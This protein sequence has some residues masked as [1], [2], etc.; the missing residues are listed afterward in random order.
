VKIVVGRWGLKGDIEPN[1]E[2]LHEAGADLMATTLA[3][4]RD[5]LNTWL[6]I[7]GG[8]QS[9]ASELGDARREAV[10]V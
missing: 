3:D 10:A 2:Q 8:E 5:Q 1:R 9:R 4:T 7:L 6:P